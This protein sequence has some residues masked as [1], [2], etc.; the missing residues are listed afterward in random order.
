M[1]EMPERIAAAANYGSEHKGEYIAKDHIVSRYQFEEMNTDDYILVDK[2]RELEKYKEKVEA[3]VRL[4]DEGKI[5]AV[6]AVVHEMQMLV[7]ISSED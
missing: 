1:S 5:D 7:L 6:M 4:M 3:V 2:Y